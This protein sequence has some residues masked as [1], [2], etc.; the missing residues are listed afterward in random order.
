MDLERSEIVIMPSWSKTMLSSILAFRGFCDGGGQR[1][2]W[3]SNGRAA[4]GWV[5]QGAFCVSTNA[6]LQ[7]TPLMH[8][9][10][11]LGAGY[12]SFEAELKG[13]EAVVQGL[14]HLLGE[15]GISTSVT[16]W[17]EIRLH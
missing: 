14:L 4:C 16:D 7:W 3:N 9:C 10:I 1:S 11:Y 13:A 5:L 8:G 15:P 17:F 6:D 2:T 12:T